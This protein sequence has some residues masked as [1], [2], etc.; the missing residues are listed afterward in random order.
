MADF[1]PR[2][3]KCDKPMERGHVPD[4]TD[5]A[6]ILSRWAPGEPA[7]R[8]FFGRIKYDPKT[9]IP[10][11]AYRCPGCGYVELYARTS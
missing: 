2:C 1:H 6:A 3:P 8:R 9:S 5:G 7:A 10:F 11:V 4:I